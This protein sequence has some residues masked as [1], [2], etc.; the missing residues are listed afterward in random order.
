MKIR[1]F[2]MTA[3]LVNAVGSFPALANGMGS[4][5]GHG[6]M[7]WGGGWYGMIFG[8]LVMIAVIAAVVAVVVLM[9]RWLGGPGYGAGAH[10]PP[11]TGE[12]AINIL[13]QRFARGEIDAAEFQ[14][15][16]RLLE[17]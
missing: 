6:S 16:K 7:M 8:P 10:P 15:R 5:D 9:I 17:D 2:W 1:R 12:S 11:S 14:E 3:L 13:S 4:G